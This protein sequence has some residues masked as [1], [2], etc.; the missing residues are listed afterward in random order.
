MTLDEFAE[1]LN[2]AYG[3]IIREADD[4]RPL[5]LYINAL[6][7]KQREECAEMVRKTGGPPELRARLVAGLRALPLVT[8]TK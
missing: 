2:T 4:F 1:S 6:L 5:A 7:T 8:E 3:P